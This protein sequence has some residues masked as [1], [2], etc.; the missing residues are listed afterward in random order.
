M[1]SRATHSLVL[2]IFMYCIHP[3]VA[4]LTYHEQR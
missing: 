3:T 4:G 1:C 2:E